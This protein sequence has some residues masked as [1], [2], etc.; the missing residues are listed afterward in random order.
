LAGFGEE[1]DEECHNCIQDSKW[2]RIC[3]PP[4]Y[5]E[6][7]FHMIFDIKM[8]DFRRKARFVGLGVSLLHGKLNTQ[9]DGMECVFALFN[10]NLLLSKNN[11]ISLRG[12]RKSARRCACALMS[13]YGAALHIKI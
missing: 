7:R 9:S 3:P 4:A 5:Q 2:R 6:I 10:F 12:L 1:G 8:E 13:V 11:N